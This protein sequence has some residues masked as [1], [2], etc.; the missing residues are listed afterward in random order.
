MSVH[1]QISEQVKKHR[2][3]QKAFLALDQKREKA[4]DE[5]IKKARSGLPINVTEVNKITAEMNQIANQFQFPHR[6]I[7]TVEM[8]QDYIQKLD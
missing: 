7:I 8:V 6:K 1:I 4:I 3:A 2:E 5:M